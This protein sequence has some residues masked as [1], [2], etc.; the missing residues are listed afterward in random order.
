MN[1]PVRTR[2]LGGVVSRG[3]EPPGYP[4]VRPLFVF[5]IKELPD[6]VFA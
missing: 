2:M 5:D 4:I 6:L 1:R 3:G